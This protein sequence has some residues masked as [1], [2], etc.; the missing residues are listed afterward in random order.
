[1]NIIESWSEIRTKSTPKRRC[2]HTSFI[3]KDYLYVF[4]GIDINEGKLNDF[5]RI[6]LTHEEP[7]WESIHSKG[8]VP[9]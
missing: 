3:Y 2:H 6:S 9:G 5:S 7:I 1:M 8:A 4:G